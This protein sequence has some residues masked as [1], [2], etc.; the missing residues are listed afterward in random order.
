MNFSLITLT[1]LNG[2]DESQ[3]VIIAE[4]HP[5]DDVANK[6][7]QIL[8]EQFDATYGWCSDCDGLVCK[9]KDCCLNMR[10]DELMQENLEL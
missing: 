2:K 5:E 9:E 4:R 8:K 10:P 6:A 7:M 3:L 1:S